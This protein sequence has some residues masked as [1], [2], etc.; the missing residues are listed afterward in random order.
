MQMRLGAKAPNEGARGLARAISRYPAAVCARLRAAGIDEMKVERLLSGEIIPGA[1]LA[2]SIFE[3]TGRTVQSFHWRRPAR[4]W[5]FAGMAPRQTS[6]TMRAGVS[7]LLPRTRAGE[8]GGD[9]PPRYASASPDKMG[10][11]D[12]VKRLEARG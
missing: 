2:H 12:S 10:A 3:A 4:A 9:M 5:W 1:D 6:Q 11:P 8:A 7:P